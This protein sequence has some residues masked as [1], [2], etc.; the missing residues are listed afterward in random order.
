MMMPGKEPI[1]LSLHPDDSRFSDDTRRRWM[2]CDGKC[3][4]WCH[5]GRTSC[6]GAYA[7]KSECPAVPA[8]WLSKPGNSKVKW[9]FMHWKCGFWNATS[10][11]MSCLRDHHEKES[12]HRY[13]AKEILELYG[14]AGQ[15]RN[16]LVRK[17]HRTGDGWFKPW[18]RS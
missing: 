4:K 17:R 9:Q 1:P 16:E 13:T 8:E 7:Y 2:Y 15:R 3:G 12:G 6:L 5:W 11:C 14:I 18:M 10:L